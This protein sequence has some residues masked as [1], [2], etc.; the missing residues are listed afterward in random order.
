MAGVC[1][2]AAGNVSWLRFLTTQ[3]EGQVSLSVCLRVW[4]LGL[5]TP[6]PVPCVYQIAKVEQDRFS[7]FMPSV[8]NQHRLLQQS[9]TAPSR[10]FPVCFRHP[11]RKRG[12][13]A[14][15][16]SLQVWE[17]TGHVDGLCSGAV[18]ERFETRISHARQPAAIKEAIPKKYLTGTGLVPGAAAARPHMPY[19][20]RS[21]SRCT[22][23]FVMTGRWLIRRYGRQAFTQLDVNATVATVRHRQ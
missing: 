17:V 2:L 19:Y 20:R 23:T 6:A 8:A 7:R 14:E 22:R 18:Q 4:H 5:A 13:E 9:P 16:G 12:S 21:R 10:V 1:C 11:C 3:Q 15:I